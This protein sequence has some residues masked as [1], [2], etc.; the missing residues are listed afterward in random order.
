MIAKLVVSIITIALSAQAVAQSRTVIDYPSGY[1]VMLDNSATFLAAKSFAIDSGGSK[2][3][4]EVH[5]C[6]KPNGNFLIFH[7]T[8]K[9]G[10]NWE[11]LT[12]KAW[13]SAGSSPEDRLALSICERA[14][15]R[16]T[17]EAKG[18]KP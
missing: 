2:L 15:A 18:A 3:S 17:T 10:A 5:D 7:Q 12:H 13:S 6:H 16:A 11:Y 9:S 14:Y 4:Y 8:T 1:S